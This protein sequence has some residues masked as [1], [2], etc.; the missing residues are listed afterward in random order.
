MAMSIWLPIAILLGLIIA[1]L[2]WSL[3]AEN[4]DQGTKSWND[5]SQYLSDTDDDE[6]VDEA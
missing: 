4:Y 6:E 3:F 2:V 1:I 5:Q